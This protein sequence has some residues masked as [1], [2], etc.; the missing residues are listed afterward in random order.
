MKITMEQ[1]LDGAL[2]YLAEEVAKVQNP[3]KKFTTLFSI[4][5]M[6]ANRDGAIA[7]YRPMLETSG[8]VTADGCVDV[9][10]VQKGMEMAFAAV[11]TLTLLGFDFTQSDIVPIVS[12]L[13]QGR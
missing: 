7:K 10:A 12:H 11:P 1:A 3:V 8:I 5:A 2:G 4:G 6:K 13:K 9:D